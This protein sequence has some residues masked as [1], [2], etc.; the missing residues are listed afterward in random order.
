MCERGLRGRGCLLGHTELGRS[1]R[2]CGSVVYTSA[3]AFLGCGAFLYHAALRVAN[4]YHT[5]FYFI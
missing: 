2:F 5:A 4:R 1:D 3:D